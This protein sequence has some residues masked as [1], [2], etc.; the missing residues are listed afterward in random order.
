MESENEFLEKSYTNV[1][2]KLPPDPFVKN[3]NCVYL[4]ISSLKF[5]AVCFYFMS[6]LRTI[7][8]Y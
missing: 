1:M 6:K 2:E 5:Y 8:I 4:W 3:Q 7:K